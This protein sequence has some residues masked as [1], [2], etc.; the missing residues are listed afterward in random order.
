MQPKPLEPPPTNLNIDLEAV[1]MENLCN[2]HQ[3]N[4]S[5]KICPQWINVLKLVANHFLDECIQIEDSSE[6]EVGE[7]EVGEVE[8]E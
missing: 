7:V 2:C 5:E 6:N 8:V 4:H 1:A 3:A